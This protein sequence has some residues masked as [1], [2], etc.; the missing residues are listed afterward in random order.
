PPPVEV[1][2]PPPPDAPAARLGQRRPE[3]EAPTEIPDEAPAE[4][5]APLAP[6]D[7]PFAPE[8]EGDPNGTVDGQLGGVPGG[9]G[10]APV[11]EVT[12]PPPAP[13]PVRPSGPMRVPEGGTS[14]RVLDRSGPGAELAIPDELRA[15][16]LTTVRIVVRVIVEE[17]GG[18][19]E[20]T[21]LRGHPLLPDTNVIRAVLR[22]RF[23]PARTA[24]GQT[25]VAIHTLPLVLDI[26]LP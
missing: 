23:E 4:S 21:V 11:E 13:E 8:N 14:P 19:R 22:W 6:P 12:P 5:D 17:D 20:C 9:T 24:D 10:T 26:T 3:L 16:G 25:F 1:E 2:A 15:S 7:D 18:V